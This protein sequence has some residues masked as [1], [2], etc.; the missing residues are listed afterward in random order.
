M[1][2][3]RNVFGLYS[4]RNVFGPYHTMSSAPIDTSTHHVADAGGPEADLSDHDDDSII[5]E[6]E[7]G[8]DPIEP[9]DSGRIEVTPEWFQVARTHTSD[10]EPSERTIRYAMSLLDNTAG[11]PCRHR[12]RKIVKFSLSWPMA[13]ARAR[14]R[15]IKSAMAEKQ[16]RQSSRRALKEKEKRTMETPAECALRKDKRRARDLAN[17]LR[18]KAQATQASTNTAWPMPD[19]D[20]TGGGGFAPPVPA[21]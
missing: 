1:Y 19:R 11:V 18:Q 21:A 20:R 17:K 2:S 12:V 8:D 3:S 10:K 16:S 9:S 7:Y 14:D 5:D 15:Q 6:S 13:L 4:S